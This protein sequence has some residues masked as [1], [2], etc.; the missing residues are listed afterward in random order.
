MCTH[1]RRFSLLDEARHPKVHIAAALAQRITGFH[2]FLWDR[3]ITRQPP[4]V[5]AS[6]QTCASP[7][8]LTPFAFAKKIADGERGCFVFPQ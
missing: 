8:S 2:S 5:V 4:S 1:S 3:A 7:E 6:S